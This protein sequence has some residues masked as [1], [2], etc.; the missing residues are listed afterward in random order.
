LG[1]ME[2]H[3]QFGSIVENQELIHG[4]QGKW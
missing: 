1:E 2:V 3:M 4:F